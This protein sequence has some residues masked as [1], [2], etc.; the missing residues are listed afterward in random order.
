ME[1]GILV[2]RP[3]IWGSM[4]AS[5]ENL[6]GVW[7]RNHICSLF[8]D[9][10]VTVGRIHLHPS[11]CSLNHIW[12]LIHISEREQNTV[13]DLE[14]KLVVFRVRTQD[15]W[16]QHYLGSCQ[17]YKAF[18][19]LPRSTESETVEVWP[20]IPWYNKSSRWFWCVLKHD[21][22]YRSSDVGVWP[23]I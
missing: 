23:K 12:S 16:H 17:K 2:Q 15:H 9:Q 14:H 18:G 7:E 10:R 1:P 21:D 13:I 19:P 6:N 20:S 8:L 3:I 22:H 11:F 5:F 4:M